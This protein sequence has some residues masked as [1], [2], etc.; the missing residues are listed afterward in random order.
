MM[1]AVRRLF[2]LLLLAVLPLQF[3]TA[4]A[5][6]Y[7]AHE[8]DS[9]AKHVGHH[10]HEHESS[11]TI[12]AD[13]ST[14]LGDSDCTYCHLSCA[15]PLIVTQ[16]TWLAFADRTS[17]HHAS[18]RFPTRDPDLRDRPNWILSV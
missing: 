1:F 3:A 16:R 6:P 7:C 4:A 18:P 5:A 11:P 12:E 14:A 15:Q 10:E 2:L 9:S 17:S 8:G 13:E